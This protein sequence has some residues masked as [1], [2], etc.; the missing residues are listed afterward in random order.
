MAQVQQNKSSI[1][2]KAKTHCENCM[3]SGEL[4][5]PFGTKVEAFPC[6]KCG[7]AAMKPGI[8]AARLI[9]REG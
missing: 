1:H 9:T 3:A 4:A 2:Y 8:R 6:P 7:V 5:V